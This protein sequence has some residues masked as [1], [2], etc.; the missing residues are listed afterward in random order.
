MK[1]FSI[2]PTIKMMDTVAELCEEYKIGEGDL[3]FVSQSTF[4]KYFQGKVTGATVVNYRKFGSG[5]PTDLMVEGIYESIKDVDYKRVFAVG[6]GTILDVAKLFAL[7]NI[8]PVVDLYDKKLEIAKTKELILVPTT[9]GT[10]SEVTNIS[11]LELTTK[12]TKFGLAVEE[13]YADDAVLVPELLMGLPFKFFATSSI[14]ALIH[15]IE[16]YT[17]PKANEFTR[18]YS[19]TAMKMILEAYKII[20][21]DGEDARLPLMKELLLASTYAGI[22]FG[23][24][25]CAAVHAMSYPLG[26]KYH[27]P[28][29]EANYAFFTGVYKTYQSINPDGSI[30]ELNSYLAEILG[31]AADEV[32]EKIEDLLNHIIVKKSL[33]EYGMT[34]EDIEDFTETVMTKQGRLMAN[35]YVELSSEVVKQIYA[36]LF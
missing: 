3:L 13:L 19:K 15:S 9:C 35:N 26:A 24:A 20:A 28:H 5:E 34:Q 16:S 21:R 10:G 27:V 36:A 4:D 7:K 14:D 25:G 23:N 18:M 30:V 31:C 33:H 12:G 6:G 2:K 29:G 17:S 32:Y 11:I 8:S 22:A 1:S